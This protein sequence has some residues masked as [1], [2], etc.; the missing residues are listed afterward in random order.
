MIVI[1]CLTLDIQIHDNTL[2]KLAT[3]KFGDDWKVIKKRD[4]LHIDH[5][6]S[7][8]EA[9]ENQVDILVVASI[10][11]LRLIS[12]FDNLSKGKRSDM[13]LIELQKVNKV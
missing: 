12:S 3:I 13:T 4:N 11:N 9:Y 10:N 2:R 1:Q 8:R 7:V 6:Y 5:I